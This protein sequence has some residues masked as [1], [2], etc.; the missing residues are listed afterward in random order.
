MSIIRKLYHHLLLVPGIS[1]GFRITL[2]GCATVFMLHR[3]ADAERGIA[4]LEPN[5]LREALDLLRRNKYEIISL[6]ELYNRLSGHGPSLDGAVVFTID[7]GYID[8]AKVACPVFAEFDCPVTT[9]VTTGFLDG[10]LWLWWDK[11]EY[12]F[13]TTQRKSVSVRLGDETVKF[14]WD[15]KETIDSVLLNFIERC[16]ILDDN[17]KQSAI[18]HL[19]E[20]AEVDLPDSPPAMYSPMTWDDVRHCEDKGMT[21]GPHTVT[22]PIL[23]RTPLEQAIFEITESWQRLCAEARHPV[24]VFCYPN[25]QWSDFGSREI[26]IMIKAGLRGA[27]VGCHGFAELASFNKD[28]KQPF[29]VRRL[30]FPD[31]LSDLIQYVSGIERCKHKLRGL[32]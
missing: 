12:T 6:A 20:S 9:F 29:M 1:T 11:I 7:D 2:R 27:V 15:A 13:A 26:E 10:D 16:K 21:F 19:A 5:F 17:K 24:P 31:T 18:V 22:H 32:K 8:Q 14:D 23:S 4:G 3:F 25:G 30:P 28:D